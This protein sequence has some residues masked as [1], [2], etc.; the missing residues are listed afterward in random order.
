MRVRLILPA[1]LTAAALA[2]SGCGAG[3]RSGATAAAAANALDFTGT[4]L[5]GA[6]FDAAGLKGK[7]VV[8][9][10]WAPWCASCAS[11]A[12]TLTDV[13]PQYKGK[14][15]IIGVAGM[16]KEAEMK[17]F[18][19]DYKVGSFPHLSDGAGTVWKKFGVTEQS[20]YVLIDRAGKVTHKDWIDFQDFPKVFDDLAR[21]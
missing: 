20:T 15:D 5:D 19:A 4:T 13:V 21:T 8:L 18:V 7:P 16:G 1:L 14:V 3:A 10:F 17:K 11:E 2:L 12:Q 6:K 9:W